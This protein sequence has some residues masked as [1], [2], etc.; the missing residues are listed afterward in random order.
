M[1]VCWIWVIWLQIWQICFCHRKRWALVMLKGT[2]SRRDVD[3]K[4]TGSTYKRM[5][6][7]SSS[8]PT[9][10]LYCPWLVPNGKAEMFTKSYP[11]SY[12]VEY[13]KVGLKLKANRLISSHFTFLT[14]Y[15]FGNNC[16]FREKLLTKFNFPPW[17]TWK[18]VS[19]IMLHHF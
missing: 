9:V 17:I 8:M 14:D 1:W 16:K 13:E 11:A 5:V 10:F 19:N 15:M 12:K 2:A 7:S 18:Y 4:I 6:L 3:R